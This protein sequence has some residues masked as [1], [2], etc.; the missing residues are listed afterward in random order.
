MSRPKTV[1]TSLTD[2]LV[3]LL[4]AIALVD[5]HKGRAGVARYA[6]YRYALDRRDDPGI[7]TALAARE[8]WREDGPCG[9]RRGHLTVI[10]G[11]AA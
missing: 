1:T 3:D 8:S 5:G 9:R 4:D 6:V 7:R 11:G 2:E 10:E